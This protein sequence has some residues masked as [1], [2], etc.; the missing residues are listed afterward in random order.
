MAKRI[1]WARE[2]VADRI[3]ILDYW[4]E[5]LGSKDYS[6]KL[7]KMFKETVQLLSHFPNLGRELENRKERLVVKDHYQIF[8]LEEEDYIKILHIWDTRRDPKDFPF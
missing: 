3:Q 5:R 6:I 7:D 8:Y 1:I 4:H 2:A